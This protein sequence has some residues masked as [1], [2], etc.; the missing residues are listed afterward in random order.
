LAAAL[1]ATVQSLLTAR[2]DRLAPRDRA[3]LQAASVLGRQFDPHLLSVVE[4]GTE[5]NER[6]A[7]MQALDLVML[8][9]PSRIQSLVAHILNNFHFDPAGAIPGRAQMHLGLVYQIKKKRARAIHHLTEARRICSQFGE[10]PMLARI[11]G[12]LVEME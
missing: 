1:P 3:L 5:I 12:A 9:A 10:T 2:V 8:T 11:E 7:A 4:D 6:L